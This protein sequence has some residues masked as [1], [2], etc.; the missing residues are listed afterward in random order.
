MRRYY[1]IGF[2][3]VV[4]FFVEFGFL[5]PALFS[6]HDTAL[7]LGGVTMFLMTLFAIGWWISGLIER[8]NKG[9][10]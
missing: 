5:L 3:L 4:A 9:E 10:N 2:L 8:L 7:V 1:A 6:A